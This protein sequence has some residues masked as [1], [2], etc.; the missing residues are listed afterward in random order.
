M[1]SLFTNVPY[2]THRHDSVVK[3]TC[4]NPQ[5][6]LGNCILTLLAF[7]ASG[8]GMFDVVVGPRWLLVNIIVEVVEVVVDGGSGL[9]R[10]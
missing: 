9:F 4:S 6:T 8:S 7:G 5:F 1:M 3:L 2:A 10:L